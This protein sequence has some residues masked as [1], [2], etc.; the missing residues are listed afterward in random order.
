[1]SVGEEQQASESDPIC[2]QCGGE[3]SVF[4]PAVGFWTPC[5]Y[6]K[7]QRR[8]KPVKLDDVQLAN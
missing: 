7:G 4:F 1:M 5:P 8:L 2:F 6:C 3:G